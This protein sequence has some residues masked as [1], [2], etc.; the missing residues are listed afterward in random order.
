MGPF[1]SIFLRKIINKIC[2]ESNL[3]NRIQSVGAFSLNLCAGV[4][5]AG[6]V[7]FGA[8]CKRPN[9]RKGFPLLLQQLHVEGVLSLAIIMVAGLFIGLVLG[10]QGYTVLN[11]FGASSQLGPMVALSV[12]REL[13]PVVTGLLFAGRTGSAL[14]AEIGLM[15]ATDQ[16]S[17]LELMAV[18]PLQ[19]ILAPRFWAGIISMPL[20]TMIFSMFAIYGAYI[21]GVQWLGLNAGSFWSNMQSSVNFRLDVMNGVAKSVVFGFIVSWVSVYQGYATAPTAEGIAHSTTRTVVFSSLL[22]LGF[23][24]VMTAMMMGDW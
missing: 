8:I 9:I 3:L 23:D 4:G 19:R 13:G 7:L 17:S 24:F 2:W 10:L 6:M 5:A 14:T 1:L 20:L 15:K 21:V 12:V 11:Q 16:L 22:I 18:D